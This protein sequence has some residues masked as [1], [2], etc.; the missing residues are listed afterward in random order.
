M[1]LIQQAGRKALALPGD[2]RD[3]AFCRKLVEDAVAGLGGLDILVSNAA[4]QHTTDSILNISDENFDWTI[5]TNIYAMF[6][7]VKP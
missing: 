5:K 7:I 3:P 6:W 2:I 1:Q 4:R